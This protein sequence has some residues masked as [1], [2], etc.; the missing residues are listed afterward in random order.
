M[1]DATKVK[2]KRLTLVMT[3]QCNFDCRYCPQKHEERYMPRETAV[4]AIDLLMGTA[5][6]MQISFYGGEPLLARSEIEYLVSYAR[7]KAKK[8]TDFP[9]S[10]EITTNGLLLD[11]EFI[12]FAKANRI[13]LALSHDGLGQEEGRIDR[14]GRSTREIVDQKLEMLLSA[15]PETIIMMTVHPDYADRVSDSIRFFREKGVRSVSLVPAHGERVEWDDEHFELLR[16]E[17]EKVERLYEEWNQGEDI[18]RFIP[19]ENK[20]RNYIRGRDADS[21]LCHFG[22]H[23]VMVDVDGN[24]YPCSHFIGRDGFCVGD[25]E[26]GPS[27]EKMADLEK[28][29]VEAETCAECALR[30]RC[31]HTCAC[32]NHGHTGNMSS[33]SALQCEYEKLIIRLADK[34]AAELIRPENTSFVERMYKE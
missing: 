32:A 34:A 1:A 14:G 31:K 24:F 10:F 18:F 16:R 13:L 7:E 17:L 20:I 23:K 9:L 19:F 27:I 29:R 22:G 33:V 3:H 25:L 6:R 28:K 26:A 8:I 12:R 15:F 30:S 21:A 2:T 11:E 5:D 4:K